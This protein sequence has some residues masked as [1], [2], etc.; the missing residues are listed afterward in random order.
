MPPL[1]FLRVGLFSSLLF[2]RKTRGSISC[3]G[4]RSRRIRG[5]DAVDARPTDHRSEHVVNNSLKWVDRDRRSRSY[6]GPHSIIQRI[7]DLIT[8]TRS[9]SDGRSNRHIFFFMWWGCISTLDSRSNAQKLIAT[10]RETTSHRDRWSLW[11][12]QIGRLSPK[13]P[14]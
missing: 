11:V 1:N 13:I 2:D 12:H 6:N 4:W 3:V 9:R 14:L 10:I 5:V 7:S 8:I